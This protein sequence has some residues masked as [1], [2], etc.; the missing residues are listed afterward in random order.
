MLTEKKLKYFEKY[1]L[2]FDFCN[3]NPKWVALRSIPGHRVEQP[4]NDA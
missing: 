1:C 2:S 4:V 3:I